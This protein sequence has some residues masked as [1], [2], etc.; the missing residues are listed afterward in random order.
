MQQRPVTGQQAWQHVLGKRVQPHVPVDQNAVVDVGDLRIQRHLW[1][2]RDDPA[3]RTEGVGDPFGKQRLAADAETGG[4]YHRRRLQA[5]IAGN[6][7]F[8]RQQLGAFR[9]AFGGERGRQRRFIGVSPVVDMQGM[10]GTGGAIVCRPS[11]VMRR[12]SSG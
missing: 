4:K 7:L 8:Q 6:A 12:R 5:D 10:P 11:S 2:L 9:L 1:P 3:E